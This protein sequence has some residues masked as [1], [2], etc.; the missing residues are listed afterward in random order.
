MNDWDFLRRVL[1]VAGVV[2]GILCLWQLSHAFLLFFGA[3]LFAILLGG[4]ADLFVR[5][6][7][8]S[9]PIA[10]GIVVLLVLLI[11]GSL[12]A[13]YGTQIVAQTNDLAQRLPAAIKAIEQRFGLGD[14]SGRLIEQAKSNSGSILF[15][16]TA[17]AGIALN[18]LSD[19]FLLLIG[20]VFL[21][22]DPEQYR[23]G[24]L[25]LVPQEHRDLARKTMN[26]S[27]RALRQWL[28]GQLIA[29]GIVGVL[30]GAGVWYI[31]LPS[32]M[33]LGV[34]AALG[35]FVPILG[36]IVSALPALF[37]ALSMDWTTVAWTLGLFLVVQQ[38]ESNMIMPLIQ[39]RM[40]SLPPAIPLFAV[41][42]FGLMFGL[43]GVVF[44]TPLA[45]LTAVL[46]SRLYLREVLEEP[47]P[48]PGQPEAAK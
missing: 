18:A 47:A 25:M 43:L 36:P 26:D 34:I 12:A 27:S 2:I 15:Q 23:R 13:L 6:L 14:I 19:L 20:A 1:I 7:S 28:V 11:V 45:V 42:A 38:L 48:I 39:N 4:A 22:V 8:M 29:M 16:V 9:R 5:H 33:A 24:A 17:L 21:A 10:L 31:G 44:A 41:L 40:V 46:V 32:P 37:L 30:I 35:E 3:V